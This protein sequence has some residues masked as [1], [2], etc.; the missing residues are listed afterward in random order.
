MSAFAYTMSKTRKQESVDSFLHCEGNVI[1]N[2][3]ET[4]NVLNYFFT[5]VFTEED[6]DDMPE[7]SN[8]FKRGQ[9]HA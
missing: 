5:S 6:I 9:V 3:L 4:A 1:T 8:L 2:I 7:P